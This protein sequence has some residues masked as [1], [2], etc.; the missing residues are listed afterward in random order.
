MHAMRMLM[1]PAWQ[2]V[3][4]I[5]PD[6]KAFYEYYATHMEPWDGPAGIVLTDGRYALLH[7][8]SQWS[9]SGALGDHQE[10]AYHHCL[11]SGRLGLLA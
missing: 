7:L 3:D 6:L 11:G 8:G 1:P 4:M 5:D 10:S 2:S 9:A